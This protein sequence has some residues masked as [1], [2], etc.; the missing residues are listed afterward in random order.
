MITKLFDYYFANLHRYNVDD[1]RLQTFLFPIPLKNCN[2]GSTLSIINPQITPNSIPIESDVTNA[3]D[4]EHSCLIFQIKSAA[5]NIGKIISVGI[6]W[7]VSL[8]LIIM[9]VK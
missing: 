4:L 5:I 3:I 9:Y 8:Y 1:G 6:F 2:S 7:S